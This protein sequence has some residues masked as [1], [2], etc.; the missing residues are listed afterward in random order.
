MS[1]FLP[2]EHARWGRCVKG[3]TR[4]T[5]FARYTHL[6]CATAAVGALAAD[7]IVADDGWTSTY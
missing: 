2:L 7:P 5:L 6:A 3:N 4:T 1:V